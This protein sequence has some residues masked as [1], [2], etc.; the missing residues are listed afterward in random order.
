[1]TA[2]FSGRTR[3][4]TASTD[5][6]H[7]QALSLRAA[8]ALFLRQTPA[9]IS[10]GNL[11]AILC[12]CAWLH[13]RNQDRITSGAS[14][15][16]TRKDQ[17]TRTYNRRS[18]NPDCPGVDCHRCQFW[19]CRQELRHIGVTKPEPH[20]CFSFAYS[21]QRRDSSAWSC[22]LFSAACSSAKGGVSIVSYFSPS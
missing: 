7:D 6:R 8:S 5:N 18:D 16:R 20:Y 17:C 3:A 12:F 10:L 22:A 4:A 13:F 2:R 15:V 9:N 11:L 21:A 19:Q 14:L 1:M